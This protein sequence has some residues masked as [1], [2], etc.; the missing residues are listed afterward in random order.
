M[1]KGLLLLAF[2]IGLT[3]LTYA[4]YQNTT[5]TPGTKAPEL[6]YSNPSGQTLKLSDIY[7]DR[8]VLVDFWASW[9]RP[10]RGANPRL[11]AMYNKYK[12]KRYEGAKKGFTVLSVSLD[13]DKNNW[14]N[15]IAKDSLTWE[16]HMSDLG[17]WNSEPA[18]IYGVS[19]IPQAFLIGPD[20]TVIATFNNAEQAAE[21]LEKRIVERKKFLGLF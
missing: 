20:G 3:Q 2:T 5:V 9:C 1:K 10:C 12:D 15:A 13:R 17:S 8:I 4:Q 7:E 21:E 6:E 14:I 18:K 11:V 19:Y 16:Y